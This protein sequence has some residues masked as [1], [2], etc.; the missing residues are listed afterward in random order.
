MKIFGQHDENTLRQLE[1]VA[2]RA[3]RA[4]LM[5]DGH[6]GYV[7][8]I[9]GVAAYDNKV[10]VVG[11]GF[12]IAC[13]AAGTPVTTAD[14][15]WRAIEE[16][17]AEDAVVCWD[18]R[19]VRRVRP[20][21]GAIPRGV[22]EVFRV[23]LANG[24][25]LRATGDHRLMTRDGW[26]CV[27]RL[28]PGDALAC[29]PFVGLPYEPQAQ[30]IAVEIP[31]DAARAELAERGLWPLRAGDPRFP[32]LLRL[33]G[34]VSGDGHLG[35][36]GKRV[37]IYVFHDAD[38][39][40][41]REDFRRLGF[42]PR[43][44]RRVR[45]E[46]RREEIHLYV[47]SAALHAL[48]AAL[49]SPVGKKAWPARPMPWLF[50]AAAWVRGLYL[51]AFCSAEMTTPRTHRSGT[52]PNL[53]LKQSGE[54][55][56]AIRFV[57]ALLESLGFRVSVAPSGRRVG[58][59]VISVLQLLGGQAEQ[60]RFLRE[61]GFCYSAERRAAAARAASVAWQGERYVR[62]RDAA[63]QEARAR[64]AAGAGWKSVIADVSAEYGVSEGFVYHSFYDDR[65]RSRRLP[66]VGT[67][68]D[69]D[70]E[71]C[72][73]PVE[74]VTAD[75][76][77]PVY[78]VVTGDPAE[79]FLASGIVAHNCGN[80]AIRTDLTVED[81]TRGL[82]LDEVRRN[83]HRLT[84]DRRV[85]RA[86]DE[87]AETI[88]F[89]IG[90]KNEADDAPVDHPLFQDPAWYAIPNVGSYRDSLRDK[91][92]R[93]L[94][95]VGSGNHYVDIFADENGFV[96]VGVHFGS[97]GLG[98]TIASD[99]LSLS[100]GGDWGQRAREAEVLLDISQPIGHDYWQ[101]MQL[102]GSYA[103]A[104]REWVARK[105]VE[106]LGGTELELVHNH[107]NF[108][109]KETHVS[110]AGEPVEYVV[111]RKGATPAFPGQKGFIGG[112]MGD[113]AVIVEGTAAAP[114]SELARVQAEALFSTVHGAGR[115][116]SRTE[117]AGKR[118]RRGEVKKRG[119]IDP[120]MV[121]QWLARKGVVLRG[122]GL[123]EA[124]QVYRRLGKVLEAQGDTIT[125]KHVLQP[126]IVV[127]AGANEID[128]YKD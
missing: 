99:F 115:V 21:M 24:R 61:V 119:K 94:G 38:A 28:A 60:L 83:P 117:A 45:A 41:M 64:K 11:V 18:G 81:I 53:Q 47:N 80:A 108:A 128:P 112:S 17:A 125:I 78:D 20:H 127:M 126:L 62:N 15:Y 93:Q 19:A 33:L 92:R 71:V 37:S 79:C 23:A 5:A 14:G 124:P 88:S 32:A 84:Q 75:G 16:V 56:N 6:V 114:D 27:D 52:L 101:L 46:G 107:H 55:Q 26:T 34:Y 35:R 96:W 2:S 85:N 31:S 67:A 110:P 9:G 113:D 74:R 77:A 89:G 8:P 4:A 82:D 40:A 1:N 98:H 59:R 58:A 10:S 102:A 65:G 122:G 49:G 42:E 121:E 103:Y 90:R 51:S 54:D 86:A 43:E 48:F 3:E 97:R 76:T 22:K 29:A 118:T 104:G 109:W 105:V 7:M 100:Q 72:W 73:V 120:R 63:K 39:T 57:A 66:G 111:V 116:M 123:D 68:P 44:N 36:D 25:E 91:A 50:E 95:T 13:L 70:G 106:L 30:E 87:I 69:A 12:D